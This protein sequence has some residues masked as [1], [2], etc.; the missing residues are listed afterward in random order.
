MYPPLLS[1]GRN[2]PY[3]VNISGGLD[4]CIADENFMTKP[5]VSDK[6]KFF[7]LKPRNLIF[8]NLFI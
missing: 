7:M 4:T 8:K 5:R 3:L 2:S 1:G 6:N